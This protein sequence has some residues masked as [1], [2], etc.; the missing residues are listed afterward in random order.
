MKALA[1]PG[2]VRDV[3]EGFW[4]CWC[5]AARSGESWTNEDDLRV[6]EG[7]FTEKQIELIQK[8]D[9]ILGEAETKKCFKS[10]WDHLLEDA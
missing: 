3:L 2:P 1:E 9:Q 8:Y 10:I 5:D 6:L 7:P 4:Y